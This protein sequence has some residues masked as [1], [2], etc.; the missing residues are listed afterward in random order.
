VTTIPPSVL[1]HIAA[2]DDHLERE[3]ERRR[4]YLN[5]LGPWHWECDKRERRIERSSLARTLRKFRRVARQNGVNL[6]GY[7]RPSL[8]GVMVS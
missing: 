5:A 6:N 7:F 2:L 1:R 8:K 3:R 4:E